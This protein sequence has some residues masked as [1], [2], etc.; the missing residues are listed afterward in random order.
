MIAIE[1]VRLFNETKE[2]LERQTATAEILRVISG[3]PTNVQPVLDTVA[4]RS[5]ALCRAEGSRVW[6]LQGG[7]LCAMTSYGSVYRDDA[8]EALPLGRGSV[9]ARAF[10]D[11]ALVHVHDVVP[12]IDSEYPDVRHL[13]ARYGFRTVLAVPMLREGESVGV[14]A[15]LRNEVRPF[16]ATEIALVQAFADQAVIAIENVRLF[17]E[18]K[19]A[20]ETQTATSDVLKVISQSPTDVQPVFDAIA[21]RAMT[22]CDARIGSVARF[23]GELVHL[24]A[25]QGVSRQEAHAMLDAFPMKPGRGA[26][27]ARCVL[28]GAP[29]QIADV[30]ADPQ[31]ELKEPARR[32]GL[33]S[34]LAVPML[35]DGRV[36]GSIGVGREQPG[37]FSEKQIKLLQT[38][39]SQALIA[40]ENVRLFNETKEALEH[41]TATAEVLQVIS[42]SVADTGPVFNKILESCRQLFAGQG[43]TISLAGEDGQLRLAAYNGPAREHIQRMYPMPLAGTAAEQA[44]R[45]RRVVH[46]PNVLGGSDVPP[47]HAALPSSWAEATSR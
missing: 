38:F 42:S 28:E 12:L 23:D 11:R 30:L 2:A 41:Q 4:E 10:V 43:H 35:Q 1:N 14:I 27:H 36:I 24:V 22:L 9:V 6:L 29:V 37:M 18:T 46:I 3:S 8:R 5:R 13:Q 15:L 19:E 20:L 7:Q 34:N 47:V 25:F 16:S 33:R 26:L 40:I 17:N 45:E 39:A 44:I 21:E 31:Y 32:T